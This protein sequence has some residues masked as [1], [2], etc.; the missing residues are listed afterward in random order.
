[1]SELWLKVRPEA[2]VEKIAEWVEGLPF[3]DGEAVFLCICGGRNFSDVSVLNVAMAR[4][5]ME[6][7]VAG[8]LTGGQRGADKMG[9][10][11]GMRHKIPTREINALWTTH[12]KAAGPIRNGRLVEALLQ[13]K[14]PVVVALP[15]EIGTPDMIIRSRQAGIN[16]LDIEE[17]LE[18]IG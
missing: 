10:L 11:W 17:V 2:F 7:P 5:T 9:T 15:G 13:Q 4:I 3:P 1:M 18:Q 14:H 16:V 6:R 12:G 8:V